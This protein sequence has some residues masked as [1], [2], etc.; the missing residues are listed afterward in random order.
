VTVEW[1][2]YRQCQVC[3]AALGEP[4][5]SLSG[6]YAGDVQV[7]ADKPHTGRKLRAGY[8]A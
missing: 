6:W 7:E 3:F 2:S 8:G 1:E 4:C 5:L